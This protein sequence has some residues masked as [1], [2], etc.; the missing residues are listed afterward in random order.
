MNCY[1]QNGLQIDGEIIIETTYVNHNLLVDTPNYLWHRIR[2][3]VGFSTGALKTLD[4]YE[5][6]RLKLISEAEKIEKH[7]K[8]QKEKAAI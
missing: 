7:I 1:E 6:M 3:S 8:E 2:Y 5:Q 4:A